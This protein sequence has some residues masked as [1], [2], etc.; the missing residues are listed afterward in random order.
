MMLDLAI[1]MTISFSYFRLQ[2]SEYL[3]GIF[4]LV[5]HLFVALI[6]HRC[7]PEIPMV[8]AYIYM[9]TG[10]CPLLLHTVMNEKSQNN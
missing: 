3:Y 1:A 10:K 6:S 4:H 7:Q 8:I 9:F 5:S 2:I